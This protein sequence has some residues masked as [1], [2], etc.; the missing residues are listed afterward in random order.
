[1]GFRVKTWRQARGWSQN[2]LARRSGVQ[3]SVISGLEA[4]QRRGDHLRLKSA[5]QLAH[6]LGVSLHDLVGWEDA[7]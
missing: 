4:L 6:S 1:M 7:P 3:Q 5:C 2:E